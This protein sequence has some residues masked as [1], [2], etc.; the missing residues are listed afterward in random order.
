M[1]SRELL[2]ISF[3]TQ[4]T[5]YKD[6]ALRLQESMKKHG[7]QHM[8]LPV[9]DTGSWSKNSHKKARIILGIMNEATKHV[10]FPG[11]VWV[12]CDAV[13][14]S[15]PILFNEICEQGFDVGAH[16]RNWHHAKN[17]LL[18]GTLYFANNAKARNLIRNWM[19]FNKSNPGI[20]E[21][22]NL[23]RALASTDN[24]KLYKLPIEY[25][26]IFDDENRKKIDPVIE[27][28]QA[29]RKARR[30]MKL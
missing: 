26:C 14:H 22:R 18:S 5:L 19:A 15:P 10:Y 2:Y 12:D 6:Y 9:K 13:I 25:C 4:G 23:W 27:H 20:W 30:V 11:F 1:N 3:Y 29:S 8:I 17:E 24:I 28:F 21:Q 16:F 7:L